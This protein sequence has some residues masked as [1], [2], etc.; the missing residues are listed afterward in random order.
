MRPGDLLLVHSSGLVAGLI[1]FGENVR[2]H[3]W[4]RAFRVALGKADVGRDDPCW[5]THVAVYVGSGRIIEAQARG[6]VIDDISKYDPVKYRVAPLAGVRKNASNADRAKAVDFA[7]EQERLHDKY[8]WLS[9][10]S[11][12]LQILTPAR[13]DISWD[14]ALI[15]SAFGAQCWEHAGVILPTRS[16]LTTLPADLAAMVDVQKS[17]HSDRVRKSGQAA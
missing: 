2:Y 12:V 3:G 14:G 5:A 9:I 4:R 6:L 17:G 13:L 15:C 16:S 1:R 8:G 10:A 11:V 7:Y